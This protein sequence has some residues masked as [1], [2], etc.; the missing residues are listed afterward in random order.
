MV[1]MQWDYCCEGSKICRI[2]R[3][4]AQPGS[5]IPEIRQSLVP[6]YLRFQSS[7]S[8]INYRHRAILPSGVFFFGEGDVVPFRDTVRH[9]YLIKMTN[10]MSSYLELNGKH[11]GL[12]YMLL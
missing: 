2:S 11:A 6:Q 10:N 4:P 9:K 7:L 1:K 8:Y 12:T 3:Q 5:R